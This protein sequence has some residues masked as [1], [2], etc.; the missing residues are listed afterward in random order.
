VTLNHHKN[1]LRVKWYQAVR[2]AGDLYKLWE[3]GTM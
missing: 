1:A 3:G 2:I